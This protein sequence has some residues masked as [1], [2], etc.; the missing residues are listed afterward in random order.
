MTQKQQDEETG[1]EQS[2]DRVETTMTPPSPNSQQKQSTTTTT[3]LKKDATTSSDYDNN[4][5]DERTLHWKASPYAVGNL[6]S[7]WNQKIT[8]C[9]GK[10]EEGTKRPSNSACLQLSAL[11]FGSLGAS[12]IG[13]MVVLYENKQTFPPR[14]IIVVGPYW[15]VMMFVTYPLIFGVTAAAGFLRIIPRCSIDV[16]IVWCVC[17]LGLIV[18]LGLVAFRN[19]GILLRKTSN[20]EED[21]DVI[22]NDQALTYRHRTAKYDRDCG[23]IIEEFDHTCPWTG[24]AIGKENITAFYVFTTLIV[25]CLAFNIILFAAVR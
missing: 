7:N 24:T 14:P 19:P 11:V 23:C 18:S 21:E 13:N 1:Q 2:N 8:L 20:E 22:W 12:R 17:S 25:V 3:I 6:D 16:T 10:E 9:C 4:Q 15:P 5:D